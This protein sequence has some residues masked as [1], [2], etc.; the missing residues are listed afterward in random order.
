MMLHAIGN[1]GSVPVVLFQ[2]EGTWYAH[3]SALQITG[4][5]NT[6][7]EARASFEVMLKEF[8]RCTVSEGT[9]RAELA[10]MGAPYIIFSVFRASAF[11]FVFL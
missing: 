9:L 3:C 8:F 11:F 1:N 4:Y 10:R 7:Q 5:G 2:E 6:E